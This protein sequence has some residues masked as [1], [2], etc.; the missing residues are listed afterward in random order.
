M[1]TVALNEENFA[2]TIDS[3]DVVLIDFW[4]GWC[5]PCM[6]FAPIYDAASERHQ[7][8]TFAKVDTEDQQ[9]L[10]GALEIT[11]IPTLMAFRAG[12]LVFRQAGLLPGSALD[13]L[14]SQVKELDPAELTK[15][16]EAARS[17]V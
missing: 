16:A 9:N 1:A 6:R 5:N 17:D 10:A 15:Q 8:V 7:D 13:D 12:Y 14:I 4:A 11:S 2:S 3:N